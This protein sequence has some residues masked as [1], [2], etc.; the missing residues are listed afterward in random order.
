[1]NY[2]T[3]L[4]YTGSM[5]VWKLLFLISPVSLCILLSCSS[6]PDEA[7]SESLLDSTHAF[8]QSDEKPASIIDFFY[9]LRSIHNTDDL[10]S[11]LEKGNRILLAGERIEPNENTLVYTAGGNKLKV[12]QTVYITCDKKRKLYYSVDGSTWYRMVNNQRKGV[13]NIEYTFPAETVFHKEKG[14]LDIRFMWRADK[15]I[16]GIPVEM[17]IKPVLSLEEGLVF[18]GKD[19]NRNTTDMSKFYI[20]VPGGSEIQ[21]SIRF[22]GNLINNRSE[23]MVHDLEVM[24]DFSIYTSN[25][26]DYK[27]GISLDGLVWNFNIF[28][29]SYNMYEYFYAPSSSYLEYYREMVIRYGD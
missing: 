26:S 25:D 24:K 12:H 16:H 9:S 8:F 10:V 23:G 22:S 2:R 11:T 4:T 18:Y 20:K 27:L 6:P 14:I 13:L 15:S 19:K 7:L 29:F 1:M 21:F 5:K 28:A 3:G 17:K